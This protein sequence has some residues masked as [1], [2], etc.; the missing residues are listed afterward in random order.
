VSFA[1]EKRPS[2]V[3]R[4]YTR[5]HMKRRALWAVRVEAGEVCCARCGGWIRPGSDW[6]LDHS[7][8]RT[9]Y[10]GPSHRRCNLRAAAL[11]ANRRR[12]ARR[13]EIPAGTYQEPSRKS[14]V[15]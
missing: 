5:D 8:D 2:A 6:H 3:A 15:W 9:Q 13:V 12:K 7:D 1:T 10:L 4:G 14:R 11:K